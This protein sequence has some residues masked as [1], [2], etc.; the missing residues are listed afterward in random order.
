MGCAASI[1]PQDNYVFRVADESAKKQNNNSGMKGGDSVNLDKKKRIKEKYKAE[2]LEKRQNGG[3][4]VQRSK[5]VS[6]GSNKHGTGASG[7]VSDMQP[8]R[9]NSSPHDNRLRREN[10]RKK[11]KRAGTIVKAAVRFKRGRDPKNWIGEG[12][13]IRGGK[14]KLDDFTVER[15]PL[16]K[17][18]AG[19]VKLAKHNGDKCYYA[20]KLVS[21]EKVVKHKNGPKH[22]QNEKR[23]L[24]M[25][26]NPFF[27]KCF[28]TFQDPRF[29]YFVLNYIVGGELHRLLFVQ[30]RF[31]NDMAM[32]YS[33]EL[34]CAIKHLHS[35][36]I[37]YRDLKPE[38]I[39][40]DMDGHVVICDLG[41]SAEMDDDGRCHTKVGTPHYLAPEILDMHSNAGYTKAIDIWSWA[42]VTY[43]MLRGR[44][45]FGT[46][47]DTAYQVYLRVMKAKYKMPNDITSTAKSL[48]RK[49]LTAKIDNRLIEIDEIK[50][51]RWFE[52]VDWKDVEQRRLQ[53]PHFPDIK[54]SGDRQAYEIRLKVPNYR[55]VTLQEDVHFVGF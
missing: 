32:F 21:K 38:N 45:A 47:H 24:E 28:G 23:I 35:L 52:N 6:A 22:L 13:S 12:I 2:L 48:I 40:I 43:E 27:I 42:L 20:L 16:G 51:H 4:K 37:M 9:R 55:K 14:F 36:N 5:T 41:F 19:F 18:S 15:K 11:F 3:N 39:L 26:D 29:V 8:G 34:L 31:S 30:K 46:A 25:L 49:L 33:T 44:P 50:E 1:Q 17:G 7:G 54:G 10:A 53:P